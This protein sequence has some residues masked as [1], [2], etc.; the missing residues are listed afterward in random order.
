MENDGI[1]VDTSSTT[2]EQDTGI[3]NTP[4]PT[5]NT[6][7]TPEKMYSRSQVESL[8]KKRVERSHNSFYKRYGVENLE[9]LDSLF[10]KSKDY[11]GLFEKTKNYDEIN[12]KYSS[13]SKQVNDL[14]QENSF[15]KNNIEPTRYGDIKAFFKG[16]DLEFSDEALIEAIKTHPEWL[17][18]VD[19]KAQT[20]IKTL[21]AENKTFQKPSEKDLAEK[22]FGM[23]FD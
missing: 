15:L 13:L 1:K 12:E 2:G 18:N 4:I 3:E 5:D 6:E 8:M 20:T 10:A 21:G 23:K 14:L 19:N 16:N 9:Q 22:I 7:N 11:D 17:K